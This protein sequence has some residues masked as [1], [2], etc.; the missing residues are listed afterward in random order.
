MTGPLTLG[1]N[2]IAYNTETWTYDGDAIPHYGIRWYSDSSYGGVAAAIGA[3]YGIRFFTAGAMRASL[4]QD[5]GF[6]STYLM[7]NGVSLASKYFSVSGG[8]IGGAVSISNTADTQWG[9]HL[10][11]RQAEGIANRDIYLMFH[12]PNRWYLRIK[13]SSTG[14]SLVQGASDTLVDLS[15]NNL[16]AG[17]YLASS[18]LLSPFGYGGGNTANTF[19]TDGYGTI[20]FASVTA[21]QTGYPES[22][23]NANFV[24]SLE[25]HGGGYGRQFY[26][27]DN[28]NMWTRL[29]QSGSW[30]TWHRIARHQGSGY[31]LSN[32]ADTWSASGWNRA[33]ALRMSDSNAIQFYSSTRHWGI[34]ASS[35]TFYLM[36]TT[37]D[38]SA[39]PGMSYPLYCD[40]SNFSVSLPFTGLAVPAGYGVH[41]NGVGGSVYIADRSSNTYGSMRVG[42]SKNNYSGIFF[43]SSYQANGLMFNNGSNEWG[44]YSESGGWKFY[45]TGT[46]FQVQGGPYKPVPWHDMGGTAASARYS[47]GTAAPSGGSD[48]DVYFQYT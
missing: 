21:T 34:G 23:D 5:G 39:S 22:P 13:G 8:T 41:L 48:G 42:G 31:L 27:P 46:T 44:L 33:L 25:S 7:E 37:S 18:Y 20:K 24:L 19:Y 40:A 32:Y 30:G 6:S 15:L 10:E 29:H 16:N 12:Q 17:G 3:Y 9:H 47:R 11:L 38:T 1:D 26:Y 43:D 35:G 4:G 36:H 2:H 45:Y 28:E 14:F